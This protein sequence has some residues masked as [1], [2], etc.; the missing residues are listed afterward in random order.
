M[1]NP[2]KRRYTCH[3]ILYKNHR[4]LIE[5]KEL[6][7]FDARSFSTFKVTPGTRGDIWDVPGKELSYFPRRYKDPLEAE[8]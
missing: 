7:K 3:R 1:L 8:T 6:T 5:L 2:S 4:S